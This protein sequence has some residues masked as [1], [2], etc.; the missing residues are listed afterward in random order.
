M[1]PSTRSVAE[2]LSTLPEPK[3]AAIL[4]TLPREQLEQIQFQWKFWA[5]PNQLEPPGDWQYWLV[6]AGRGW[7]K[8][9]VGS[10]FIRAQVER[11]LAS[12]VAIVGA[13]SA[14]VRDVQVEGP[15]GLLAISPPWNRPVY[16]PSKRRLTWPN[17]AVATCYSADEPDRLRG[18]QHDCAWADELAAWRFPEAW[19]MLLLGLRIGQARCVIT[20]TPRPST[21]IHSIRKNPATIETVGTSYQNRSNLAPEF[22]STIISQYEGTRLGRQELNAEL[23]EDIEG[24]LW[25]LADIDKSRVKDPPRLTRIVVA[26]DPATTSKARS[27]Q[28]GIVVAGV[29]V[30]RHGYVLADLSGRYTPDAWARRAIAAFD[31]H[32]AD[33]IVAEVNNG[34]ELVE[35]TLRT[36]RPNIPYKAVH[37]SRGKQVRAEPIAA[38]YEQQK[39]H[40][41]GCFAALED[42][43][44][45]Y[46]PGVTQGSP[47]R[48]DALV[49]ALSELLPSRKPA[50]SE[51][52]QDWASGLSGWR[53]AKFGY[54]DDPSLLY[55]TP[56]DAGEQKVEMMDGTYI[57]QAEW[58]RRHQ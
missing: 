32:G 38:L 13:T 15:S 6:R 5:R 7:G 55:A 12:R 42:Q 25:K 33:R 47:D 56:S 3:R 16:E 48:L 20:T 21:L 51:E 22:Y 45:N 10:E 34:G 14:D 30:E 8:T 58:R 44:T 2:L 36:V 19:S 11:S 28:T 41:C 23:L 29:S 26:I 9:R 37:A 49:W 39:I 43:L 53:A 1:K 4:K 54:A 46:V 27:D 24:A 18:P 17:G 57:S 31:E 50:F 52:P 35:H 40:H